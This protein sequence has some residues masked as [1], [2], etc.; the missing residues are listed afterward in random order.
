M[1]L[2]GKCSILLSAQDI[3]Y[4]FLGM[5]CSGRAQTT[6]C[7]KNWRQIELIF[8]L[9]GRRR[10]LSSS[11]TSCSDLQ[12]VR[13]CSLNCQ[14]GQGGEITIFGGCENRFVLKWTKSLMVP[15]QQL[16]LKHPPLYVVIHVQEF[17]VKWFS[18]NILRNWFSRN[19]II[20]YKYLICN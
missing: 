16:S 2:F 5:A 17:F 10:R 3:W 1:Y 8:F 20:F 15:Q 4:N 11:Y 9:L 19:I 12:N 7:L 6:A 14:I 13:K 18:R